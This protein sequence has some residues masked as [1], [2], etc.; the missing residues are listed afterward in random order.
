[1]AISTDSKPHFLNC[2]NNEISASVK[3][4]VNK[5]VLIPNFMALFL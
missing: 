5:N 3:G 4:E 2:G 1:M